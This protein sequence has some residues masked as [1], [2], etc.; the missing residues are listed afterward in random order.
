MY[1]IIVVWERHHDRLWKQGKHSEYGGE[2]GLRVIKLVK[3]PLSM[4]T[5]VV[6]QFITLLLRGLIYHTCY[7][8]LNSMYHSLGIKYI[9]WVNI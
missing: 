6:F 5:E 7:R 9:N 3:W 1:K 2:K 4:Y 8:N